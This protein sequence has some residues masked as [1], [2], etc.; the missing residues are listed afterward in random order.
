[1]SLAAPQHTS[2]ISGSRQMVGIFPTE[3][4]QK[5]R[6]LLLGLPCSRLNSTRVQWPTPRGEV[7]N[8]QWEALSSTSNQT[9]LA[10]R[11]DSSNHP[12]S[13]SYPCREMLSVSS[14][15]HGYVDINVKDQ[16][17]VPPGTAR[18]EPANLAAPPRGLKR[19]C[20]KADL[21]S[22]ITTAN[23]AAFKSNVRPPPLSNNHHHL[24]F[25]RQ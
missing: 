4:E 25:F 16:G 14:L 22:L 2:W 20:Q 7:T 5:H 11:K 3:E 19:W 6:R 9:E 1:M 12:H 8:V 15:P 21:A 10:Q 24:L 17:N 23:E 13:L 18:H